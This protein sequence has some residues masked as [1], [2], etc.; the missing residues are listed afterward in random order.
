MGKRGP[1]PR[2]TARLSVYL[3]PA[4]G[5]AL[6][7]H[8]DEQDALISE[9]VRRAFHEH[10]D[11]P[12]VAPEPMGTPPWNSKVALMM[13]PTTLDALTDCAKRAKRPV[14]VEGRIAI[15]RYLQAAGVQ[16]PVADPDLL[17]DRRDRVR[18]REG[19][20]DVAQQRPRSFSTGAS[21]QTKSAVALDAWL[22]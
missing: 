21:T 17:S 19:G 12:A 18:V 2:Y 7:R 8:A 3:S 14:A 22:L 11:E 20:A 16:V 5:E 13:H 9:V 10:I 15:H 4:V 6:R 1:R